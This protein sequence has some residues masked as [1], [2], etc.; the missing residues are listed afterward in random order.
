M[1]IYLFLFIFLFISKVSAHELSENRVNISVRDNNFLVINLYMN[2]TDVLIGMQ[3]HE[4]S[5]V[6]MLSYMSSIGDDEFESN[7]KRL[8]L[9]IQDH[10]FITSKGQKILINWKW[11]DFSNLRSHFKSMLMD[12]LSISEFNKSAHIHEPQI[13]LKGFATFIEPI[14]NVQIK[15]PTEF[16]PMTVVFSRVSQK[17]LH[18]QFEDANFSV[19]K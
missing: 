15:V 9:T 17:T 1:K 5:Q 18:N 6:Q 2:I 16:F 13:L 10:F 3:G 19:I 7:I 4:L 8:T 11:D 14:D 12:S